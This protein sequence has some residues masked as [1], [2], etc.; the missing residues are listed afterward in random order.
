MVDSR[1]FK[2][3]IWRGPCSVSGGRR[4]RQRASSGQQ[5]C[6]IR[7][8]LCQRTLVSGPVPNPLKIRKDV[9]VRR[10]IDWMKQAHGG[11]R[12]HT[13]DV[14]GGEFAARKIVI[15]SEARFDERK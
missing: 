8:A 11:E 14:G 10:K 2:S 9:R 7:V 6:H 1:A 3:G 4:N 13:H 12:K 5:R 15:L